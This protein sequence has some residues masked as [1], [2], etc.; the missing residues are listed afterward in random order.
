MAALY[1]AEIL[2]NQSAAPLHRSVVSKDTSAMVSPGAGTS[3]WGSPQCW[4]RAVPR[5]EAGYPS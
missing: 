2:A 3:S 1:G 5:P 4:T